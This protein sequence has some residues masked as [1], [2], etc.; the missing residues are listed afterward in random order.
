MKS[1]LLPALA[2][3]AAAGTAYAQGTGSGASNPTR[4]EAEATGPQ[5]SIGTAGESPTKSMIDKSR[6]KDAKAQDDGSAARSATKQPK[7]R[8]QAPAGVPAGTQNGASK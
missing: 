5:D 6:K 3:L 4:V 7:T 1:V 8:E 2:I